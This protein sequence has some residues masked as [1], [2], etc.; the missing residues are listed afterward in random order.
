MA[1]APVV[2]PREERIS[3]IKD[4]FHSLMWIATR[5]FSQKLQ[6]FGLTHP[7][8]IALV[9]LA[10]HG[11]ACTMSDLTGVTFQDPPTM[12]GIIDRLVKMKLVQRTRSETDRRVVLVEA[13]PAGVELAERVEAEIMKSH[14]SCY[15]S[16]SDED[17]TVLEQL[18]RYIIRVYIA[19]Y[20][21]LSDAELDAEIQKLL[22]HKSDPIY[23]AK[24]MPDIN[25]DKW[26]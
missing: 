10:K 18:L 19:D 26:R 4:A 1:T 17:L 24:N 14:F 9:V 22:L 5:K 6:S 2:L 25:T 12:T 11:Q 3:R 7:Q 23:Y 21:S 8:F 20:K 13:T 16:V 15:E